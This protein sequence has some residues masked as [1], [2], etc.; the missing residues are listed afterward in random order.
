[1]NFFFT[2][3]GKTSVCYVDISDK[4]IPIGSTQIGPYYIGNS[5]LLNYTGK[6]N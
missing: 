3:G 5:L 4:G 6:L 2:A 1:M